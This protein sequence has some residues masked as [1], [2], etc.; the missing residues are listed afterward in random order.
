MPVDTTACGRDGDE[1]VM[2]AFPSRRRPAV[3]NVMCFEAKR[4]DPAER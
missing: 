4:S 2:G 1:R 3:L